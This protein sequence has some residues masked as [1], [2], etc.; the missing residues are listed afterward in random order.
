M[1]WLL[2][3]KKCLNQVGRYNPIPESVTFWGLPAA[4]VVIFRV[5]LGSSVVGVK[6][7][8]MVQLAPAAN[9]LPQV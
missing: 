6:V 8:L 5:A 1:F 4:L 3:L 2:E 9:V 7:T